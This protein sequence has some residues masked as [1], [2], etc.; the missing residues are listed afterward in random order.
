VHHDGALRNFARSFNG[1]ANAIGHW[2]GYDR[3]IEAD[4]TEFLQTLF[5]N[6]DSRIE[7]G[8]YVFSGPIPTDFTGQ[9]YV[10]LGRN[11]YAG[12]AGAQ[13]GIHSSSILIVVERVPADAA[14]GLGKFDLFEIL[15]QDHEF[16]AG[17]DAG[18]GEGVVS[19]LKC[20]FIVYGLPC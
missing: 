14:G 5:E 12:S 17:R 9:G 1:G 19:S 15:R 11:F 4:E 6:E 20:T 2:F 18:G 3:N 10:G 13:G 8:V 7:G 16:A